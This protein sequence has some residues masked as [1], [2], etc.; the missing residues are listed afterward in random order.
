[1]LDIEKE[2]IMKPVAGIEIRAVL[3][4]DDTLIISDS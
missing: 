1:M 2:Q 3:P 4:N